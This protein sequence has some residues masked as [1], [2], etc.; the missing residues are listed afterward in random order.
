[1]IEYKGTSAV[2]F[3]K[4]KI[5]ARQI[6]RLRETAPEN[7]E[8]KEDET[9]FVVFDIKHQHPK[10]MDKAVSLLIRLT[11]RKQY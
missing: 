11:R 9:Q 5:T 4:S 3:D 8:F 6:K 7:I 10:Y 1:M 2:V